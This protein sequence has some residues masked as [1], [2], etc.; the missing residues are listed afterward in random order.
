MLGIP[1]IARFMIQGSRVTLV[2]FDKYE[3][4]LFDG[5]KTIESEALNTPAVLT[6]M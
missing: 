3:I 1:D 2:G 5:I 4:T 6:Y